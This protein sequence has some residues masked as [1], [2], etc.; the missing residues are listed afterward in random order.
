MPL[1]YS[2]SR[3]R[4]RL[5]SSLVWHHLSVPFPPIIVTPSD[6][7]GITTQNGLLPFFVVPYNPLFY[8]NFFPFTPGFCKPFRL[9]LNRTAQLLTGSVLR[10]FGGWRP[11][12]PSYFLFLPGHW[13]PFV[14][15]DGHMWPSLYGFHVLRFP[16]LSLF[17]RLFPA[18]F[19][20]CR[21][22]SASIIYWRY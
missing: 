9:V 3:G 10:L 22:I 19:C 17:Q 1:H 12:N 5:F 4:A 6:L 13:C 8:G 18:F 15:Y 16:R 21:V 14:S 20:V 2:S 7:L 11:V